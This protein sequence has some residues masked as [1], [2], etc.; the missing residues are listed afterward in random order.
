M[1]LST[2]ASRKSRG[3]IL[4]LNLRVEGWC[5][6]GMLRHAHVEV[7][8]GAER[9]KDPAS[10][11]ELE[12]AVGAVAETHLEAAAK[13]ECQLLVARADGGDAGGQGCP[14]ERR[15]GTDRRAGNAADRLAH[16]DLDAP[17]EPDTWKVEPLS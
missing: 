3:R 6:H 10:D 7:P 13:D 8:L 12:G 2:E 11:R 5:G 4:N 15:N 17:P 16:L 14:G 1:A 9:G